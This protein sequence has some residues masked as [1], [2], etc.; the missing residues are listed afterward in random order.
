[1]ETVTLQNHGGGG[2]GF[3][4][5]GNARDGFVV[6][7]VSAGGAAAASGQLKAGM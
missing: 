4:V 5:G 2:L 7:D 3:D 1:M 6:Q